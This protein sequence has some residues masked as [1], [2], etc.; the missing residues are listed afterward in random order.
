MLLSFFA[1]EIVVATRI[2]LKQNSWAATLW[3]GL[4]AL[5]SCKSTGVLQGHV[6]QV[7]GNQMP[8][9]DLPQGNSA[10]PFATR[11]AL[12]KPLQANFNQANPQL[13]AQQSAQPVYVCTTKADGSFRIRVKANTYSLLIETPGGWWAPYVQGNLLYPITLRNGQDT[14]LKLQVTVDA[15]F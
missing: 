2:F 14:T 3:L 7:T 15:V 5:S 11:I 8:S 10:Q 6:T 13:L 12:F 9:P 4:L 1:P